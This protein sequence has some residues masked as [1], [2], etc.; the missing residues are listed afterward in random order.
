MALEERV[1]LLSA[2]LV[3]QGMNLLRAYAQDGTARMKHWKGR[4]MQGSER[5]I[6][7]S[8]LYYCPVVTSHSTKFLPNDETS[9]T[10]CSVSPMSRRAWCEPK[11]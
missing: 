8:A 7:G 4:G 2:F 3:N 5:L 10:I 1:E 9:S 6:G 11:R